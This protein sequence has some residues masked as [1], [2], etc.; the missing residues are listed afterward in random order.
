MFRNI[1]EY[2]LFTKGLIKNTQCDL[3]WNYP[4]NLEFFITRVL[5]LKE[6]SLILF[7]SLFSHAL[8]FYQ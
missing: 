4:K 6:Y 3:K 7:V 2:F 1:G 5:I 8:T